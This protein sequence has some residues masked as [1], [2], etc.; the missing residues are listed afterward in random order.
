MESQRMSDRKISHRGKST[1]AEAVA[2]RSR[3]SLVLALSES[4][5]LIFVWALFAADLIA[6]QLRPDMFRLLLG[7]VAGYFLTLGI[8]ILNA[9]MDL[10]E[11]KINS[12]KRPLASGIASVGTAKTLVVLSSVVAF[13]M[14]YLLGRTVMILFAIDFMLG[15]SYSIPRIKAKSRFPHKMIVTAFGAGIFSLTGGAIAG[16]LTNRGVWFAAVAFSLFALVTLLLG[17]MSD[18]EG[19]SSAGVRTLPIVIGKRKATQFIEG[20]PISIAMLGLLMFPFLKMNLVFPFILLLLC[21][22]SSYKISSLNKDKSE[23]SDMKLKTRAVKSKMRIAHFL[24]QL[25]FIIGLI[26]L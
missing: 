18:I 12:P 8:Y 26:S 11:D 23:L 5:V 15:I 7:V 4:R 20:L 17:D 21:G 3:E 24:L 16:T 1:I 25:T 13:A 9:L 19:D 2:R 6:S 14:A 10:E 22:Y